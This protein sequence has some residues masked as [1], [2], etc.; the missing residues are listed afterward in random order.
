LL[1]GGNYRKQCGP[2]AIIRLTPSSAEDTLA[3]FPQDREAAI[4]VSADFRERVQ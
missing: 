1:R 3:V 2:V 4:P